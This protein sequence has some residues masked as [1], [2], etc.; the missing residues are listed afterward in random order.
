MCSNHDRGPNTHVGRFLD[1]HG[2]PY[3]Y[4]PTTRADKKEEEILEVVSDT[5]FLV[6]AR[7]MQVSRMVLSKPIFEKKLI[8]KKRKKI[9]QLNRPWRSFLRVVHELTSC[10]N[11]R[12]QVLSPD[13][14]RRYGKDIINIHHGL[15]P[16]FKGANPYRQVCCLTKEPCLRWF[17]CLLL[18]SVYRPELV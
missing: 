9:T 11:F 6:L 2:I 14:L 7:Y 4:M 15:L 12:C 1:R 17:S 16:S 13:F 18:E 5:D 3:H 10:R 8:L